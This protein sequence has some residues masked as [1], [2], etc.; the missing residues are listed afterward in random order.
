MTNALKKENKEVETD[1]TL[2][3]K[4]NYCWITVDSFSVCIKREDEGVG[5][6]IYGKGNESDPPVA[7]TY[8]FTDEVED[9]EEKE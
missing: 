7:S 2:H 4:H 5:V 6:D 8:A 3:K 1:Y 9:N